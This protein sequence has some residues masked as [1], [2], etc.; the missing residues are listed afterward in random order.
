MSCCE[1][2]LIWAI[3]ARRI[4]FSVSV[5]TESF[6]ELEWIVFIKAIFVFSLPV[7]ETIPD[8]GSGIQPLRLGVEGRALTTRGHPQHRGKWTE[9]QV[10]KTRERGRNIQMKLETTSTVDLRQ[11]S[12]LIYNKGRTRGPWIV[13]SL[14]LGLKFVKEGDAVR[15]LIK[16]GSL[17]RKGGPLH[18]S[19]SRHEYKQGALRLRGRQCRTT[20]N[21]MLYSLYVWEYL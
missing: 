16:L 1:I 12:P 14:S 20:S 4:H 7:I 10:L 21:S 9:T 18:T 2:L 19:P 13:N 6:T 17:K 15:H 3:F 11:H 8:L 5:D